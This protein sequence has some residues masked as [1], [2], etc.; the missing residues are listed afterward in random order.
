[1]LWTLFVFYVCFQHSCSWIS[2]QKLL[3]PSGLSLENGRCC[4][5]KLTQQTAGHSVKGNLVATGTWGHIF[6]SVLGYF[7]SDLSSQLFCRQ[8]IVFSVEFVTWLTFFVGYLLAS[9]K[10]FNKENTAMPCCLQDEE[11]SLR[12][13]IARVP[14][15]AQKHVIGVV[16]DGAVESN[17]KDCREYASL[18]VLTASLFRLRIWIRHPLAYVTAGDFTGTMK[19]AL[20]TWMW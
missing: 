12:I 4:W 19:T 2:W 8:R 17:S 9:L 15:P 1:M 16:T 14:A 10:H 13:S 6:P 11:A 20:P 18:G 7:S 3:N 5:R